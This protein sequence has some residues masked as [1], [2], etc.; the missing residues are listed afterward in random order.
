MEYQTFR[1]VTYYPDLSNYI[2]S[3]GPDAIVKFEFEVSDNRDF[4]G[5]ITLDGDYQ[6][7]A[8][9]IDYVTLNARFGIPSDPWIRASLAVEVKSCKPI[10]L[11]SNS[12]QAT[13]NYV[14]ENLDAYFQ[15]FRSSLYNFKQEELLRKALIKNYTDLSNPVLLRALLGN[16]IYA[17]KTEDYASL[18]RETSYYFSGLSP[19]GCLKKATSAEWTK[20]ISFNSLPCKVGVFFNNSYGGGYLIQVMEFE[21]PP[22]TPTPTPTP[23]PCIREGATVRIADVRYICTN[24]FVS[25]VYLTEADAL[26]YIEKKRVILEIEKIVSDIKAQRNLLLLEA[27][28]ITDKLFQALVFNEVERWSEF[29]SRLQ[30]KTSNSETLLSGKMEL[31]ILSAS[32]TKLLT[33]V[34]NTKTT[35]TCIKGKLTKKVTAINPKCLSGYKVKK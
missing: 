26:P 19:I 34:R 16:E 8:Y 11:F 7:Y 31:E 10:T 9:Q 4:K 30:S 32:T 15:R 20:V 35:I 1:L 3:L 22:P 27:K 14:L 13:N 21:A 2:K 23:T 12:I 6:P 5:K 25:L 17:W 24:T 28:R 29:S 18:N 33:M